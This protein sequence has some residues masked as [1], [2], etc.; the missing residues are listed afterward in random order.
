[1]P[2]IP[3]AELQITNNGVSLNG[4]T[5]SPMVEYQVYNGLDC[6]LTYEIHGVLDEKLRRSNSPEPQLVYNFERGMQAPALDMML[7]G[8]KVNSYWRRQGVA[9]LQARLRKLEIV[10][11]KYA[12]IVWGK[13]LNPNSPI[14]MKAFFYGKNGLSLPEQYKFEKGV[15]KVS[16]NRECLEKLMVYFYAQPIIVCILAMRDTI[17]KISV[18]TTEVDADGRMRTSYN[19]AGTETGRWSSSANAFGGGTNLQNITPELRRMFESDRGKKLCYLDLEQAESRVV[20]L[21]V[22]MVTGDPSYLNACESGDLHTTSAKLIWDNLAWTGD[23]KADKKIAEQI[24][25][26]QYT[27]RD[28]SKRG[29]HGTN[30]YGK[31][32]TMARHLKVETAFMES[33]QHRYFGAF[34]GIPKWHLWVKQQLD[35]HQVLVTPLGRTRTFFGRHDDDTTLREAIAFVP[36]SVVGDLLNYI[37]Y[38]FFLNLRPMEL[39]AQVHD[40][41]VFQYPEPAEVDIVPRALEMARVPITVESIVKP[42]TYR[43]IT[44]PTEC[45]VGWNWADDPIRTSLGK[46]LPNPDGLTKWTGKLDE[47]KRLEGLAR[48]VS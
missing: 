48:I 5:L 42:G 47:R 40:A 12:Q 38:D 39:L 21:L 18:L 10:L 29:G 41:I 17:K 32:P 14:Q 1:M 46:K 35:L 34:P 15:K 33:F 24:F 6:G 13:G 36:Q 25:Y 22:W 20:G 37:L 7:R 26:R 44:I 23:I 8:F 9:N 2:R 27:Y 43:T 4:H 30:Y 45:K 28:M 16:T 11:D 19:V 3:T 31:P